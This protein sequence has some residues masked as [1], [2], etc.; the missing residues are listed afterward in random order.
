MRNLAIVAQ[1]DIALQ[2]LLQRVVGVVEIVVVNDQRIKLIAGF[3]TTHL[4]KETTCRLRGQPENLRQRQEGF[5]VVLLVM[6]L[7]DLDGEHH[8]AEDVQV[9]TTTDIAT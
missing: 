5:V 4:S 1:L 3:E 7:A 8:H 2:T 6:H 9:V